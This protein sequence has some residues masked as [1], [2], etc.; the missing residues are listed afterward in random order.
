MN[1]AISVIAEHGLS[2]LTLS[3]VAK[4]AGLTAGMVNFHFETKQDLLDATLYR[5]LA[6]MNCSIA[7][8]I[9]QGAGSPTATLSAFVEHAFDPDV[10][11]PEKLAALQAFW[12]ASSSRP[13]YL[14]ACAASADGFETA[15]SEQLGRLAAIEG[16]TIDLTV[17]ALGLIGLI[18]LMWWR[19]MLGGL[20]IEGAKQNCLR[21]LANHFPEYAGEFGIAR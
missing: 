18:D 1:A 6:S 2:D 12:G 11:S 17:A 8:A 19:V 20:S 15:I 5:Q 14:K 3:K 4:R 21:Y 9:E 13:D 7:A 16:K 10:F